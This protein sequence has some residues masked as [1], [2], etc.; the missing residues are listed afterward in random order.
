MNNNIKIKNLVKH[1]REILGEELDNMNEFDL[2]M[3][4]DTFSDMKSNI[5]VMIDEILKEV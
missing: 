4:Q 3:D 5:D 2:S 1:I